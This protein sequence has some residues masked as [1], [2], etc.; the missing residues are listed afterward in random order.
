M[1]IILR[2]GNFKFKQIIFLYK[3]VYYFKTNEWMD[4]EKKIE[5]L[6]KRVKKL[7]KILEEKEKYSETNKVS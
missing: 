1:K 2:K 6:E 7:E 5:E 3:I 4:S